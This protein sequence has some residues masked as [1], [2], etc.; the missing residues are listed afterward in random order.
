[1]AVT[2]QRLNA[3]TL[4]AHLDPEAEVFGEPL[5]ILA[6]NGMCPFLDQVAE[7]LDDLPALE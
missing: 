3:R 6:D 7:A 1:L 5:P 4:L 2:L